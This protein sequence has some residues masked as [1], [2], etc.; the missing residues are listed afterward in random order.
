MDTVKI[1]RKAKVPV[2]TTHTYSNR[3]TIDEDE[4]VA[5]V[6][7]A[8][9]VT[10]ESLD[11]IKHPA[12]RE[13]ERVHYKLI[14]EEQ[15]MAASKQVKLVRYALA[16]VLGSIVLFTLLKYGRHLFSS[17]FWGTKSLTQNAL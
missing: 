5:P 10:Q 3:D 6:K 11:K 17:F 7:P 13:Q 14:T 2:V 15:E 1:P 8:P 12:I 16:S 4:R 9:I